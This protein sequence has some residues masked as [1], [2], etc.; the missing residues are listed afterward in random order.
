MESDDSITSTFNERFRR[1]LNRHPRPY[2]LFQVFNWLE[3]E[4]KNAKSFD[5]IYTL[6]RLRRASESHFCQYGNLR[7]KT[8]E[9]SER[10]NRT[11]KKAMEKLREKKTTLEVSAR[12]I[13]REKEKEPPPE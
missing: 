2:E 11:L 13:K 1:I 9:K 4:G 10:V 6:D 12:G 5:A 3:S 8:Q 7:E